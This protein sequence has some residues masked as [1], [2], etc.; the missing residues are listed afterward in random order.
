M[1]HDLV[2]QSYKRGSFDLLDPKLVLTVGLN[3][4]ELSTP[5]KESCFC[6]DG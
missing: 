6:S 2:P 3:W 1:S 4:D 5:Y